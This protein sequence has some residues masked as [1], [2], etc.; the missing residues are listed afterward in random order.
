M[1][2]NNT[3]INT[4]LIQYS[5]STSILSDSGIC[6]MYSG[7]IQHLYHQNKLLFCT[8]YRKETKNISTRKKKKDV[9]LVKCYSFLYRYIHTYFKPLKIFFYFNILVFKKQPCV[10]LL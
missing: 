4:H 6:T 1:L 8:R 3:S 9:L 10:F 7:G 2:L 5:K